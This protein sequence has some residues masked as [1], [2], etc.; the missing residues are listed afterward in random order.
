[1]LK[2]V[3]LVLIAGVCVLGAMSGCAEKKK[4]GLEGAI[5]KAADKAKEGAKEA[6]KKVNEE[7]NK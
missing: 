3:A 7:L 2:R 5:D 1:M 4:T 6:E